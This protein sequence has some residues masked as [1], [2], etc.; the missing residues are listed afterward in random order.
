MSYFFN[1][2]LE[3]FLASD[4][5][6]YTINSNKQ[7]QE[8]EY[9]LLWLESEALY[10]QKVYDLNYIDFIKQFKTVIIENDKSQIKLWCSEI[11][12]KE[13]QRLENSKIK[14]AEFGIA[15]K[16]NHPKT[17]IIQ[18][19]DEVCEG[20]FIYKEEYGVSGVGTW[21]KSTLPK[22][23][24]YPLIKDPL[25]KR[26][27][28]FSTLI[29]GEKQIV[30][31]NHIDNSFQYKGTTVGLKFDYFEWY[32]E[33]LENIK[34]IKKHYE[35]I[36]GPWSID[37]FLY[38]EDNIEKVYCLSEVNARK[39]MGYITLKLKES[40]FPNFKYTRLRII[41]NKKI[42][43]NFNHSIVYENFEKK[44]I[45]LSPHGNVFSVFLIAEN[46]L[47]ELNELEDELFGSLL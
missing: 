3:D 23:V 41:S 34:I 14:S 20:D 19:H 40:L 37:S 4:K 9:F 1:C 25:L 22:R 6:N 18:S 28:D 46:S 45:A 11:W 13:K 24:S 30:Y 21:K 2:D 44:I 7:N 42:K 35:S 26:T 16:L 29:D 31:Q 47:G 15:N 36:K 27:F 33:Y 12:D 17:K 32:P 8:F 38:Q 10:T 5:K 39:T 43:N